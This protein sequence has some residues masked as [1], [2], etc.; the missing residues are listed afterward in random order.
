MRTLVVLL[1]HMAIGVGTAHAQASLPGPFVD[2]D[3][4]ATHV[5][6]GQRV[7]LT[8]DDGRVFDGHVGDVTSSSIEILQRSG[9]ATIDVARVRRLEVPDSIRD[10][11]KRGA[12]IGG[13]GMGIYTGIIAT[14]LCECHDGTNILVTVTFAG[15][16][17]G[18]GALLG[19]IIDKLHVGRQTIFDRTR[20]TTMMIAPVLTPSRLGAAAAIRW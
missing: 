7:W 12:L 3:T 9:R 11:V 19:G 18:S 6:T 4:A 8:T 16:G 14:S 17:A 13:L 10:G 20:G 1:V 2:V 15:F 5:R